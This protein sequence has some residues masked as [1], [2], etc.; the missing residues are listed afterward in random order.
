MEGAEALDTVMES[1]R[2]WM[3]DEM[4]EGMMAEEMVKDRKRL[5]EEEEGK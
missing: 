4:I 5:K 1:V 2:G 3:R